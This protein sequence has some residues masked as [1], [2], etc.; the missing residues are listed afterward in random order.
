MDRGLPETK[1]LRRNIEWALRRAL[2][3]ATV[4]PTLHRLARLA[5][6]GTDD[7][8]YA[9]RRLAE[10]LA[11]QHPWRAA[12]YAKRVLAARP[13]DDG[14]WSIL[15]LCHALL[16]HYRCAAAAY[17][18]ALELDPASA[19]YAHNLGHIIDVA[20]GRPNEAIPWLKAAYHGTGGRSDV[21]V[22]FA[23]A[24][25]RAGDLVAARRV[26]ERALSTPDG[27]HAREHLALARW[28]KE[29]APWRPSEPTLL[30]RCPPARPEVAT[31]GRR[32]ARGTVD[33]G[34]SSGRGLETTLLRGM[35]R[36]PLDA[37]QRHRACAIASDPTLLPGVAPD[38]AALPRLAAAI[39]YAVAYMDRV[40]LT[41]ADVAACFRVSVPALRGT[42]KLLRSRLDLLPGD[43]RF[44][45][46]RPR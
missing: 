28:I 32:A 30:P 14:A 18:R 12:L 23:H 37:R 36:L 3:P 6:E 38:A 31:W 20:L 8:L 26:A 43:A 27:G 39:A 44:A 21:A 33:S 22:S 7:R 34:A 10:L 9:N 5:P 1:R 4:L 40:P 25:G 17:R 45:T 13:S 41:Q 24:L 11:E 15:G 46:E 42:F 19:P 29:G 16:G 35:A 2:D